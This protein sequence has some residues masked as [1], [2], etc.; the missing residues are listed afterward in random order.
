[1]SQLWTTSGATGTGAYRTYFAIAGLPS[2]PP[3]ILM[4][5]F[6]T[7][8]A[9][10]APAG[11]NL[12]ASRV[13]AYGSMTGGLNTSAKGATSLKAFAA[14]IGPAPMMVPTIQQS[15]GDGTWP[16]LNEA[17]GNLP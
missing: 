6:Y 11:S 16:Y 1:M 13:I 2:T 17:R 3:A 5:L 10:A 15:A 9:T 8:L 14:R 7:G 4:N 12:P